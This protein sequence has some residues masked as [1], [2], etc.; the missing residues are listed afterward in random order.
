[1]KRIRLSAFLND[2]DLLC[3]NILSAC[4]QAEHWIDKSTQY[5]ERANSGFSQLQQ[6]EK[7]ANSIQNFISEYRDFAKNALIYSQHITSDIETK[8]GIP[9]QEV[10]L[11]FELITKYKK[12]LATIKDFD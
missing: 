12:G 11:L 8:T 4:Y 10:D 7:Y 6:Q 9:I 2:P 3:E 5:R 1:V